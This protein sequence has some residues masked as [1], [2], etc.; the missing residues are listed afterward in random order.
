MKLIP[1]LLGGLLLGMAFV[2]THSLVRTVDG[3][4]YDTLT[5]SSYFRCSVNK[6]EMEE[7]SKNNP[8]LSV[9]DYE[10]KM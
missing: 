1:W 7:A 2:P 5:Y 8:L 4:H 6:A 9:F 3:L 10:C